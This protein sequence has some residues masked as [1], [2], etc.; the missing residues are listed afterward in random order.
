MI[1]YCLVPYKMGQPIKTQVHPSTNVADLMD[2]FPLLSVN[3]SVIV[4]VPVDSVFKGHEAEMPP[5]FKKGGNI[6]F[7]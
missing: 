1:R 5:F 2:I 4:K 7:T 6:V 3:D